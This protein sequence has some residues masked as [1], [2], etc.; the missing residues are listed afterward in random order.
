MR[1]LILVV[2]AGLVPLALSEGCKAH[3][4]ESGWYGG[5][6]DNFHVDSLTSQYMP[7]MHGI[8]TQYPPR[9]R[10]VYPTPLR[11]GLFG[12]YV[13]PAPV[14]RNQYQRFSQPRNPYPAGR[15][16]YPTPIRSWTFGS[17]VSP[18]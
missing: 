6:N 9:G 4:Q 16:N 7:E 2:V 18:W 11:E 8:H 12:R 3:A 1:G 5:W 15:I 17:G 13:V 14:P 10:T